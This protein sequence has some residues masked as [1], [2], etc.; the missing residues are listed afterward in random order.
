MMATIH[1]ACVLLLLGL[2][3]VPTIWGQA[4]DGDS[5]LPLLT[6]DEAVH[7]AT[8]NNTDIRISKLGVTKASETVA[9]AKTNYLP[10]LSTYVLAGSPLQTLNFIVPAGTFGTY[11]A[12]GPIP[13]TNSS[14]QS[15]QQFGAFIYAA[16]AQPLTQ[17]YKVKL[18][19]QQSRLGTG[20][21]HESVRAQEQ[22]TRRQVKEA[23]YQLAETQAQVESAKT[24]FQALT[25]LSALT[26]RRLLQ[27]T[28]LTSDALTIKA[29]LKQQRYQVL[30]LQDSFEVQRESLNRLLGRELHTAFKVETQPVP[31]SAESDLQVAQKQAL[32][33]RP[34]LREAHLQTESAQMDVRRERAE[35]IPDLSVQLSYL[36]F[37]NV[38]FLPE[39]AGNVGFLLQWQPFDWGYKK[40]KIRELNA[41]SKQKSLTEQDA[42]QRV[43]LD[44]EDK[45]RKL[46][47]A[48]VLLEAQTDQR[49][50]EQVKLREVTDRYEQQS[51]LLSDLLQQQAT[52]SQADA[53]YQQALAG[54]WTARAEFE[55][56]IGAD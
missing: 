3:A 25:E 26:G 4:S 56:A 35:Y 13:A 51:V 52:L 17:L 30:S 12:T 38:N 7:I 9:Q 20:L 37:Q 29:K 2:T 19:V 47:Q 8:A 22:E 43:L 42:K 55:K 5:D 46:R 48:R 6:L 16:A 44:V 21:A 27:K 34:E 1:R 54:F 40:H 45:F 32:E 15:P 50:A 24:A 18:A 11:A 53:Q 31:G 14:I 23:Y 10:Q 41:T 49:E 33:Q 28:V 39:N 36:S